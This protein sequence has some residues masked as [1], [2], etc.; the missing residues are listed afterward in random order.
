MVKRYK[1]NAVK[2]KTGVTTPF[3]VGAFTDKT[4][5]LYLDDLYAFILKGI[6]LHSGM[7]R[8]NSR[9]LHI[10]SHELRCCENLLIIPDRVFFPP[11]HA[12]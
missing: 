6:L 7:I 4:R 10:A 1:S 11:Q 8:A 2:F 12:N 5:P 3:P 9:S